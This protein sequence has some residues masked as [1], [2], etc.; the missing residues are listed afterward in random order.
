MAGYK[1]TVQEYKPALFLTFDGEPFDTGTRLFSHTPLTVFDESLVMN[2]GLLMVGSQEPTKAYRAGVAS[3]VALEP[4]N[5]QCIAFGTYGKV[6]AVWPKAHIQVLD[7]PAYNTVPANGSFTYVFMFEKTRDESN[8]RQLENAYYVDIPKYLVSKPGMFTC[9][10]NDNWYSE[11]TFVASFPNGTISINISRITGFYA[12]KHHVIARFEVKPVGTAG[13]FTATAQLIVNGE[14][15]GKIVSTYNDTPPNTNNTAPFEFGGVSQNLANASDR[16]TSPIYLDQIAFWPKA[17]SDIE[18]WRLFKKV[19]QYRDMLLKKNPN[20]YVPLEDDPYTNTNTLAME[21]APS[22]VQTYHLG[23]TIRARQGPDGIPASRAVL[24]S[25][26]MVLI[27]NT[28]NGY[29][30]PLSLDANNYAIEFWLKTGG[31]ERAVVLS[32]QGVEKPFSGPLVEL[33]VGETGIYQNGAISF[34]ENELGMVSTPVGQF[35]NTGNWHHIIVQRR[36]GQYLELFVN[37]ELKASKIVPRDSLNTYP[38]EMTLLGAMPGRLYCDGE[39]SHFA[40]YTGKCFENFEAATRYQYSKIYRVR[41]NTTLRGVPYRA[42]VRLYNYRT[43]ELME[44]KESQASDGL[45]S[46]YLRDNSLVCSQILAMNDQNVRVRGFGPISPAE[47]PDPP[48][49]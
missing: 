7:N 9:S 16:A 43:G 15:L 42:T 36:A 32:M 31:T 5:Q 17:L 1:R 41:G 45:F 10:I 8:Y 39:I 12:G 19:W 44:Q 30:Q 37:G 29:G 3:L 25:K 21:R 6:N 35:F 38:S 24:L 22:Y 28:S 27:K 4:A 11:D 47:L 49:G 34:C 46:F 23:S 18:A 14:T 40:M 33:N 2:H 20:V 13:Q 26:G 48:I